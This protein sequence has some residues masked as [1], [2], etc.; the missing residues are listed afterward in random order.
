LIYI[1]FAGWTYGGRLHLKLALFCIVAAGT[2]LWSILPRP[3]R[4]TPQ[5]PVLEPHEHPQL[6]RLLTSIAHA[7]KQEMPAA[8]Y[9]IPDM[10]AWV[11]HHGGF[12]GCG[13]RRVMGLGLPLLQVLS[14]SQLHAVLAHEFGH[15]HGSDTTLGPWLYRTRAAIDR[16]LQGLAE[17]SSV[18]Q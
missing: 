1:P 17:R 10:N 15:F 18:L 7:T 16:T 4:F 5:G 12:M 14:T 6:F 8:V 9:V 13:A 11:T 2:I 3:E